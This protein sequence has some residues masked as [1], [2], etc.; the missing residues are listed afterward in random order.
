MSAS[1]NF[2]ISLESLSEQA[3]VAPDEISF[4]KPPSR[5]TSCGLT[6]IRKFARSR[7]RHISAPSEFVLSRISLCRFARPSSTRRRQARHLLARYGAAPTVQLKVRICDRTLL[8]RASSNFVLRSSERGGRKYRVYRGTRCSRADRE[9]RLH[10]LEEYIRQPTGFGVTRKS[11][12]AASEIWH[13]ESRLAW[14][15]G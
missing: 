14:P 10:L 5:A 13:W 9:T 1:C 3:A 6:R 8:K 12:A 7:V 11:R 4:S 15:N 2:E